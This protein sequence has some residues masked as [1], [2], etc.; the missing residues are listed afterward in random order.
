MEDF[1]LTISEKNETSNFD[2]NEN[3]TIETLK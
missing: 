2:E 3:K 1:N